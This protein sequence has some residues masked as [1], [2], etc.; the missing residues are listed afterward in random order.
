MDPP[1][2]D[3]SPNDA[4]MTHAD[5]AVA[6]REAEDTRLVLALRAG[7]GWAL[8]AIWERYSE[9]V[10]RYFARRGGHSPHDV[11]DLTQDVFLLVFTGCRR[12]QKPSS[13]R[14]FVKSVAINV[15]RGQVRYRRIRRNVCLSA[16][17]A[18]PEIAMPPCADDGDRHT[19]RRC[20]DA[21]PRV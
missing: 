9:R 16:T 17:G 10:R 21:A 3:G 8:D 7:E 13:L 14:H 4:A 19:L 18:L 2:V 5:V 11:D 12:I 20:G 15:H 1:S 6:T